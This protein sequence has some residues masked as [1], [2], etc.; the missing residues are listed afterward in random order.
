MAVTRVTT[1]P[2]GFGLP[3]LDQFGNLFEYGASSVHVLGGQVQLNG[4]GTIWQFSETWYGSNTGFGFSY[5][6]TPQ[7]AS[8]GTS[9]V[10]LYV[11][12]ATLT[13]DGDTATEVLSP[14]WRS[15][16]NPCLSL[17][18]ADG[19]SNPTTNF[20]AG[21]YGIAL[22]TIDACG[23]ILNLQDCRT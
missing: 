4:A 5:Y 10:Q 20:P 18:N 14:T 17:R 19:V 3:Q 9:L 6:T 2:P 13:G 1:N 12:P 15:T 21:S 11:D 16:S 22:I 7:T 8:N 23:R